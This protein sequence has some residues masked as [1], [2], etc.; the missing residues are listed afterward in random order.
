MRFTHGIPHLQ[1]YAVLSAIVAGNPADLS[2]DEYLQ[3]ISSERE[4]GSSDCLT[5]PSVQF[6]LQRD[7]SRS[8]FLLSVKLHKI[9]PRR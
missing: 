1:Y 3:Y 4:N 2:V 9:Q 5:T 6:L 7:A 8:L